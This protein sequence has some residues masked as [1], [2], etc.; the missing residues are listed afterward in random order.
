MAR[1]RRQFDINAGLSRDAL[2]RANLEKFHGLV[3]YAQQHSPYYRRVILEHGI[4]PGACVPEDFP[5]LTKA[6]FIAHFDDIVTDR[7]VTRNRI[8]A[9]LD[10]STNPADLFDGRYHVVHT[11]GTSGTVG[12]YV[13]NP[14]EWMC[15]SLHFAKSQTLGFRRRLAYVGATRGHFTGTALAESAG[16][17]IAKL[18]YHVQ[19]FDINS[20]MD[21]VVERLNA[22]KPAVV[23]G[24]GGSLKILA[25]LQ[26]NGR[27]NI[28]PKQLYYSGEPLAPQDR[29]HVQAVFDTPCIN[30]Y[31]CS[32]HL[33][34][35]MSEPGPC[36]MQLFEDDLIFEFQTDHVRITNLYNRSTPLI[37]Y[38]LDDVLT[39]VNIPGDRSPFTRVRDVVGRSEKML[40]FNN[41]HGQRDFIHPIVIAEFYVPGLLAFQVVV[42]GLATFTFQVQ[43]DRGLDNTQRDRTL[44]DIRRRLNDLLAQKHMEN[45]SF[46]IQPIDS[47]RP[48][49]HTGKFR[50]IRYETGPTL[51]NQVAR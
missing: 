16:R 42:K 10:R 21:Q 14:W 4:D 50:L 32:E 2:C 8:G 3:A 23:S 41:R 11:S 37:R 30:L 35:G 5:V 17:G 9:F 40:V 26:E 47:L 36:D 20:P 31:I 24:Y 18:F 27:L 34:M 12:Y 28:R 1:V 38:R 7:S 51:E 46:D 19:T 29:R 48:D 15:G 33:M 39:P 44:G 13:Y 43:L 22:F 25:R 6:D 45:V 49:P